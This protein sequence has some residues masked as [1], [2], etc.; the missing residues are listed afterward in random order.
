VFETFSKRLK[1]TIIRS[2]RQELTEYVIYDKLSKSAKDDEN[3]RTLKQLS[4]DE[5]EH[6][7]VWK[8]LTKKELK[9][10]SSTVRKYM[11]IARLFGLTFS[12]KLMENTEKRAVKFYENLSEQLPQARGIFDDETKHENQLLETINEERLKYVSAV[13]L[14]LNDALVELTGALAGFTFALQDARLVAMTGLITGIAASL[15]MGSSEYL[16]TKSEGIEKSARKAATY[17]TVA[18]GMTVL[19]LVVPFLLLD[20][21]YLSLVASICSA[22]LILLVFTYY[23]SVAKDLHFRRRFAETASVSLGVAFITFVLGL[24]VRILFGIQ[25]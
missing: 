24:L 18:Y 12:L 16:S 1:K 22:I 15:S 17:T 4:D 9:P 19:A 2:Q 11:L 14:G 7:E 21:I 3:K 8:S 25:I 13:V 23:I 6:Y 5:L 20:N 10:K